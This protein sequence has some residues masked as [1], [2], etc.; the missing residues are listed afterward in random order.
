MSSH[1]EYLA[2]LEIIN[3]IPGDQVE[4]PAMPVDAYVQEAEV[5][6]YWCGKDRTKLETIG[7][8][9]ELVDDIP[10]RA[11]AL[12]AADVI[13]QNER[14]DSDAVIRLWNEQS[15]GLFDFRDELL[16]NFRFAFRDRPDLLRKVASITDGNSNADMIHDLSALGHLG[17][18]NI[19]LLTAIAFDTTQL[20]LAEQKAD[21]AA[22]LLAASTGE[23]AETSEAKDIRDRAYTLL[24]QAVDE[25]FSFGRFA[26]FGKERRLKGYRSDYLRQ[27]RLA[28]ERKEEEEEE[29]NNS[30]Q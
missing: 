6:T 21:E 19:D 10:A 15:P 8:N 2:K 4:V 5:L 18:Q 14:F 1:E 26:F 13:W 17:K 16:R 30:S 22:S 23:R 24:K 3:A 28:R 12:R 9:W 27:Q 20:D 29:N 11:G 7:L 25:I